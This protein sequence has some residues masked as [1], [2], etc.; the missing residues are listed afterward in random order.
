[1]INKEKLKNYLITKLNEEMRYLHAA[2]SIESKASEKVR[3]LLRGRYE[4][5]D[6]IIDK[7]DSPEFEPWIKVADQL[8]KGGDHILISDGQ[9]I[10]YGFYSDG[11]KCFYQMS[12]WRRI[13]NIILWSALPPLPGKIC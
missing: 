1:M 10:T 7:I 4:I 13:E 3:G 11:D 5:L 6:A 2:E 9:Q 12:T 8:P